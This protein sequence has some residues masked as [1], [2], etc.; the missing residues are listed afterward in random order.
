M[1]NNLMKMIAE[2]VPYRNKKLGYTLKILSTAIMRKGRIVG[3]LTDDITFKEE[4]K[5]G[6]YKVSFR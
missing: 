2:I 4:D 3:H 5:D 1:K 6:T